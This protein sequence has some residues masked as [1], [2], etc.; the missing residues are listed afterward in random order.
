MLLCN[1]GVVTRQ[2][3]ARVSWEPRVPR[4]LGDRP[5][6]GAVKLGDKASAERLA[7][8]PRPLPPP[9]QPRAASLRALW[10]TLNPWAVPGPLPETPPSKGLAG[11]TL[12]EIA[13]AADTLSRVGWALG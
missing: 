2:R 8:D 13:H 10:G 5:R 12:L 9:A 4:L 6:R 3:E 11:D 1:R 7:P